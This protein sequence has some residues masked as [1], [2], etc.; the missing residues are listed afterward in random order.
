MAPFTFP[1]SRGGLDGLVVG[2]AEKSS[3]IVRS[4]QTRIWTSI[5]ECISATGRAL[6]PAIHFRGKNLDESASPKDCP[7]LGNWHVGT[8]KRGWTTSALALEW[9]QKSFLPQ[10][11]IPRHTRLLIFDGH[12][13]HATE[14]YMWECY[15]HNVYLLYLPPHSSHVQNIHTELQ[16]GHGS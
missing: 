14:E 4:P 16:T 13:S 1:H 3:T 10:T 5:I 7:E 12:Q 11:T 15:S 6:H 8:S 9:L 2:S